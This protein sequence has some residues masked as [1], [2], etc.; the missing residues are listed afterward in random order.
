MTTSVLNTKISKDVDKILKTI[1]LKTTTNLNTKVNEVENKI[2]N[3]DKY[4][5][6]ITELNE[7]TA[8]NFAGRLKQTNLVTKT[9]FDDK[10]TSYNR[11]ITSN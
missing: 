5:T 7:L 1:N 11:Q 9:D 8:E 2:P 10:L 6:T 4:I 3:H